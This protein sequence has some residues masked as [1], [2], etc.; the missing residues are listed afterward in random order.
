MLAHELFPESL[1][2]ISLDVLMKTTPSEREI[3]RIVVEIINELRD[4]VDPDDSG[5][6]VRP[7]AFHTSKLSPIS[8][9]SDLRMGAWTTRNLRTKAGVAS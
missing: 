4:A 5:Q 2:D 1:M 7:A 8:F 6:S 3:I 9:N